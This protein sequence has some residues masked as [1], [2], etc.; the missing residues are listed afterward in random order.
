[1][2]Y[3]SH[4]IL[5]EFSA[6][7]RSIHLIFESITRIIGSNFGAVYFC[8]AYYKE[9]EEKKLS[10]VLKKI[11]KDE[12]Y[13]PC[14]SLL[15]KKLYFTPS[16]LGSCHHGDYFYLLMKNTG[17]TLYNIY[18]YKTVPIDHFKIFLRSV[19][20]ILIHFQ[21]NNAV[22]GDIKPS[23]IT[24]SDEGV[25]TIID[26]GFGF[27]MGDSISEQLMSGSLQT[28]YVDILGIEG[29]STYRTDLYAMG[30]TSLYLL[31]GKEMNT[32]AYVKNIRGG[33]YVIDKNEYIIEFKKYVS[34]A[35]I[36]IECEIVRNVILMMLAS[37]CDYVID[38]NEM[39]NTQLTTASMCLDVL[40]HSFID[41]SLVEKSGDSLVEK[42]GN[43]LVD[44][45]GD[46]L[47]TSSDSN[48]TLIFPYLI[49]LEDEN[50]DNCKILDSVSILGSP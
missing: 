38:E 34:S 42:S 40:M 14:E 18:R 45:S 2:P 7:F 31:K 19:L 27:Y 41:D 11:Q 9:N 36:S 26:F 21:E 35:L 47:I 10:L 43:S 39:N 30:I 15:I 5:L 4:P 46:I 50:S 20:S 1:M 16:F 44:N 6:L 24:I 25:I 29:K 48:P 23:N 13:N 37:S 28:S 17:N 3:R 12:N 8:T 49:D 22:H 32:N 33:G